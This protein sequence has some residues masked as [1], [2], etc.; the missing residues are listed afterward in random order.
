MWAHGGEESRLMS[1]SVQRSPACSRHNCYV[2]CIEVFESKKHETG[3]QALISLISVI[4][5]K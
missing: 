3:M 4:S 2:L 1:N 5:R